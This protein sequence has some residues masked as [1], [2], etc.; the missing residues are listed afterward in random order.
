MTKIE[1][2]LDIFF[3]PPNYPS[4]VDEGYFTETRFYSTMTNT[5]CRCKTR[6]EHYKHISFTAIIIT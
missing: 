6:E 2:F 4:V 5:K 3:E 1:Q